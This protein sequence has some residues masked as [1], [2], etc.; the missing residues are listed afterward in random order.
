MTA[1]AAAFRGQA[2]G[3]AQVVSASLRRAAL[4]AVRQWL[5][6]LTGEAPLPKN[7]VA[8]TLWVRVPS[9]SRGVVAHWRPQHDSCDAW[10]LYKSV[11][12]L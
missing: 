7:I 6:L 8:G 1:S 3:C 11:T 5:S 9:L 4:T 2:G 12:S 10:R